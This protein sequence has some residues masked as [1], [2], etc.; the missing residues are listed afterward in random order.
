MHIQSRHSSSEEYSQKDIE[1]EVSSPT[2]SKYKKRIISLNQKQIFSQYGIRLYCER[3][4]GKR[5]GRNTFIFVC[6][7]IFSLIGFYLRPTIPKSID[8]PTLNCK[9]NNN[10]NNNNEPTFN[11]PVL[12]AVVSNCKNFH[13]RKAIRETWGKDMSNQA[14]RVLFFVGNDEKCTEP[15]KKEEEKYKDVVVLN[16]V[17]EKYKNLPLKTLEIFKHVAKHYG[18]AFHF[19]AKCDDDVF[20]DH[21]AL[22]KFLTAAVE[23]SKTPAEYIGFFHNDTIPIKKESC[24]W[25]DKDYEMVVYPPYAGGMFYMVSARIMQWI[26]DNAD[27]LNLWANEDSTVGTWIQPL[28]PAIAHL[29]Q[30]W[31]SRIYAI[32]QTEVPVAIHVEWATGQGVEKGW[33]DDE[34]VAKLLYKMQKHKAEY[35]TPFGICDTNNL[36]KNY[37]DMYNDLYKA[38]EE[39]SE[40]RVDA[41]KCDGL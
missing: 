23:N 2:A 7:F 29:N 17:P 34:P 35:D 6:I 3:I 18:D 39:F 10:N 32:G 19:I 11:V 28:D 8:V 25:F 27:N 36:K 24:K 37:H 1:N 20:V 41:L 9:D 16:M 26:A 4:S 14:S 31:P 15:L 33:V 13:A 5:V 12:F 22:S 40:S 38:P 30:V 21:D